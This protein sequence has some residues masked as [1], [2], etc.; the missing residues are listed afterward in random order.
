MS[1][2][3]DQLN[4]EIQ[5]G[6]DQATAAIRTLKKSVA[7]LK[8]E[9]NELSGESKDVVNQLEDLADA[10]SQP[11]GGTSKKGSWWNSPLTPASGFKGMATISLI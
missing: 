2:S 1:Q 7:E 5:A 4:I 6:A 10:A 9:M 11:L 8:S 3:I